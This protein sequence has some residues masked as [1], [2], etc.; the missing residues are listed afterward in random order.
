MGVAVLLL[1]WA[2]YH[3]QARLKAANAYVQDQRMAL[4]ELWAVETTQHGHED[5]A[6]A[7]PVATDQAEEAW[8][9]MQTEAIPAQPTAASAPET[10]YEV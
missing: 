6:P 9:P 5:A 2:G 3:V 8:Q 7:A 10:V 4:A 1:L